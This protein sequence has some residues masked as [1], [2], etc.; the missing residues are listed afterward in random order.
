VDKTQ[1][2]QFL[3]AQ[4]ASVLLDLLS[5][6]YDEMDRHQRRAVFGRHVRTLPSAPVDGEVLL[7]EARLFHR[8]SLA[9]VYYT[10]FDINSKNWMHIP[11]E[12]EEWFE[13]KGIK[14]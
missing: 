4:D 12:T 10:P 8:D 14:P 2:F 3:S 5:T 9:E 11:D 1:L 13:R 7:D 6:A